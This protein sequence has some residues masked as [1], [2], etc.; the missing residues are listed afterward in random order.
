MDYW[1][2]SKKI[3]VGGVNSPVRAKVLPTPFI[4][5]KA[6]GPYLY[7]VDGKKILDYVLGYGPLILGHAHPRVVEKIKEQIENGSLYGTASKQEVLLGK[8]ILENY[9]DGGKIRFVNSGSEATLLAIRIARAY[10][11]RKFIV[12]FKECYHGSYDSFLSGQTINGDKIDSSTGILGEI[13]KY[14]LLADYNDIESVQS[15]FSLKG[16]E[17]AAVIVEPVLGNHGVIPPEKNFL[18]ELTSITKE[19]GSLLIFDE[20]ITGFRIS[21][22]GAKHYYNVSPDLA[23]FGKIIGGGLP[24]G[25]VVGEKKIMDEVTPSGKVFNAGTFNGNPLSMVAGYATIEELE[26]TNGIKKAEENARAIE[27]FLNDLFIA[28]KINATTNRVASMMQIYFTDNKEI[29]RGRDFSS[30]DEKRYT[31]LH[32]LLLEKNIFITPSNREAIFT[33]TVHDEVLQYTLE[34]LDEILTRM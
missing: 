19:Y 17:I 14:T 24:I 16:E 22:G 28:K 26:R 32:R 15:I 10:T 12:K 7:T 34:K 18:G 2:L 31:E 23:T 6:R 27:E 8:K 33:S 4:T 11:N 21:M 30:V 25:A 29:R 3:F 20:V 1:E 13:G 5:E 9:M